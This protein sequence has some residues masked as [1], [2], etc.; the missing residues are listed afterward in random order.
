MTKRFAGCCVSVRREPDTMTPDNVEL[1]T[2]LSDAKF[3]MVVIGGVAAV[4]HAH[5]C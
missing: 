3:E 4:L 1:L 5:R 2:R